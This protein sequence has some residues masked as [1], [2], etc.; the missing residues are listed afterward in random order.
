MRFYFFSFNIV[1]LFLVVN[2]FSSCTYSE[3][4]NSEETLR[5]PNIIFILT[6]DLAYWG[7]GHSGN[8]QLKTPTLDRLASEGAR[9]SNFF[10]PTPVC[11]PAR[12][13]L[14][15]SRYG[16]EVGITDWINHYWDATLKGT[17][18]DLGL[19]SKYT[20]W[21][22]IIQQ[23]GYETALIGKWHLGKNAEYHPTNQGF[24]MFTGFLAGGNKVAN[25][26][27][28]IKGKDSIFSGLTTD[29]LTDEAI[30]Y[31]TRKDR[32]KPFFL[33][34]NYRA[35]HAPWLPLCE[36][37]WAKY[38]ELAIKLPQPEYPKLD[39]L[40]VIRRT[41]EYYGA[42]AG[43]DRNLN[44]ILKTLADT[45]IEQHTIVIFTSDHGYNIGHNGIW[46]KGNGHWIL[47]ENPVATENIPKGQ[48]PNMYDNSLKV[49]AIVKWPGVVKKNIKI[50]NTA[51]IL[52]WYPTLLQ[53]TNNLIHDSITIRGRNLLPL[54]QEKEMP[55]WNDTVY[56]EYSTHHQSMTHMR[57][58]RTSEWKLVMD[59]LNTD[60]HELFNLKDD[61]L[62]TTNIYNVPGHKKIIKELE[63]RL[64]QQMKAIEDPLVKTLKTSL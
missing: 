64:L 34:L 27:L 55:V 58:L 26:T 40:E 46:H 3:S 21:A 11:S 57:M 4:K 53:M 32:K 15:T 7:T 29:I 2:L 43:L 47:K 50:S 8:T 28:E 49:P 1:V 12:A 22:E 31:L 56:G 63:D 19:P 14:M 36:E 45:K 61:P 30:K 17:E 33:S 20:T 9:F 23:S 24:D 37:D 39:S 6:D 18:P 38:K 48:R 5:R 16:S 13:S 35:P 60:R 51:T 25:P 59:Y 54:L 42:I 52:D 41:R 62:E 10:V 44:R